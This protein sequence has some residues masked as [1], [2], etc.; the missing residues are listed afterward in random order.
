M[1]H[2]VVERDEL[3]GLHLLSPIFAAVLRANYP[4]AKEQSDA[5]GKTFLYALRTSGRFSWAGAVEYNE[6][7][8]PRV[9]VYVNERMTRRRKNS[10]SGDIVG[11]FSE[12]ALAVSPKLFLNLSYLENVPDPESVVLEEVERRLAEYPDSRAR[13]LWQENIQ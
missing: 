3:P 4:T 6:G 10:I 11:P 7:G 12:L 9:D 13:L 1:A 5:L 8:R 2:K